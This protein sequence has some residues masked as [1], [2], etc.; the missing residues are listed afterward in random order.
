MEVYQNLIIISIRMGW[1]LGIRP[2]N[3]FSSRIAR[4]SGFRLGN[5]IGEIRILFC[6]GS[7]PVKLNPDPQL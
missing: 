4:I 7:D 3:G 5:I 6:V 1:K 2:D